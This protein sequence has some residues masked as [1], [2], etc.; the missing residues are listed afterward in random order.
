MRTSFAVGAVVVV[1]VSGCAS[2]QDALVKRRDEIRSYNNQAPQDLA[3]VRSTEGVRGATWGMTVDE[4]IALRGEPNDKAENA[5]MYIERIDGQAVPST[6]LFLDGH[7]A[8]V[9]SRFDADLQPSPR[10]VSALKLK[11][12]EPLKDFDKAQS[13]QDAI[14]SAR[15]WDMITA[16]IGAS[17]VT[18]AAIASGGR[19]HGSGFY[20]W[21]Y[22]GGVGNRQLV[23]HALETQALPARDVIWATKDSDV[24]LVSL[25]SGVSEI[26]WGSRPLGRRLVAQQ[27]SGAGL[28][29]LAAS[30]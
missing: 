11:W 17:L 19:V 26:T 25:D 20:P 30:L 22:A 1:V 2:S 28:T 10:L 9:K 13:H 27:M 24:H 12:G 16:A 8:E 15:R 7:L 4:V 6:Y 5:L 21:W 18:T 14:D 29:E 3:Q 23:A